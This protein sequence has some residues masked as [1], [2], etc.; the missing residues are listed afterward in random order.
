MDVT[1][2]IPDDEETYDYELPHIHYEEPPKHIVF[3]QT[4]WCPR[5]RGTAKVRIKGK[6]RACEYCRGA[7][8]IPNSGAI[9]PIRKP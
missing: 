1:E 7:G 3:G 5:C 8:V 6:V 4:V 2:D 9:A